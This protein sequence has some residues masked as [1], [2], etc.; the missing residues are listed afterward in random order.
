MPYSQKVKEGQSY[1][2]YH[3][4]DVQDSV[5]EA[6][7]QHAYKMFRVS[8]IIIWAKLSLIGKYLCKNGQ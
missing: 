1:L 3:E 2:E 5:Y 8:F 7:L 4:E 6:V